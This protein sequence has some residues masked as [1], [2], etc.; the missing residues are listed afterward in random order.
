MRRHTF[1]AF[2]RGRY[3][4]RSADKA[5]PLSSRAYCA[6]MIISLP[7]PR[8]YLCLGAQ[9]SLV[10]TWTREITIKTQLYFRNKQHILSTDVFILNLSELTRT[11]WGNILYK[12]MANI[13][14][15]MNQFLE[16]NIF[17]YFNCKQRDT[18]KYNTKLWLVSYW[19]RWWNA[20][21]LFW[22]AKIKLNKWRFRP[23]WTVF[24]LL[25]GF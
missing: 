21:V 5:A 20:L 6:F 16:I 3:R 7:S 4:R 13:I 11:H 14:F 8:K 10:K 9:R 12:S 23:T 2:C 17:D 22:M 24:I 19:W 1:L 25:S 18:E 15:E